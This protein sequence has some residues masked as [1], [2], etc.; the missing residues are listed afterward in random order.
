MNIPLHDKF[1]YKYEFGVHLIRMH[2]GDYDLFHTSKSLDT[3]SMAR[4]RPYRVRSWLECVHNIDRSMATSTI[5]VAT[6]TAP[7]EWFL[8]EIHMG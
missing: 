7:I 2:R 4:A 8:V 1:F 5:L 6:N 3:S